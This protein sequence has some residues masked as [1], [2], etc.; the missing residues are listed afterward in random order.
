MSN[1]D[2]DKCYVEVKNVT[3]VAAR[4]AL[5]PDAVTLRGRKHLHELMDMVSAGHRAVMCY[6][7]QRDDT[8][9]LAPADTIDPDYGEALRKA[10]RHGV[11]AIAYQA[12]V[13][14]EAIR[15][16]RCLPV[17]V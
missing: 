16:E 9:Q 1:S 2:H 17:I 5:F 7:V 6:V 10:L 11:E 13:T 12:Q 15:L 3:L 14:P 4:T 8:D